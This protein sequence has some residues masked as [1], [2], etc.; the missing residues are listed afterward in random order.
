MDLSLKTVV[1]DL[2]ALLLG[3]IGGG[4]QPQKSRFLT[5]GFVQGSQFLQNLTGQPLFFCQS[6]QRFSVYTSG[7]G[8]TLSPNSLMKWSISSD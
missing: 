3:Q 7:L 5:E 2:T 6:V 8:H 1:N 4:Q